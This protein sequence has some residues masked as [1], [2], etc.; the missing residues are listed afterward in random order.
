[1]KKNVSKD[2]ILG[3]IMLL[4]GVVYIFGIS[5]LPSSMLEDDPGPKVFPLVGA[6]LII[7]GS[8]GLILKKKP[9]DNQ[10][11]LTSNQWKRLWI[12]FAIFIA[13]A[14]GL[15]LFG[16][17]IATFITLFIVSSLFA[18]GK[19]VALWKRILFSVGLTATIFLTFRYVLGMLLPEGILFR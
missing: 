17:L 1:M 19:S 7:F 16:Y 3:I 14:V 18:A 6:I 2:S 8:I 15:W 11:F 12:L 13:Y 9:E 10:Q 4:F 5:K